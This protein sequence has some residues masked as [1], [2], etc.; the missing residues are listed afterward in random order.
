VLEH[1]VDVVLVP[2]FNPVL[3]EGDGIDRD[4]AVQSQTDMSP[5]G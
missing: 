3:A 2:R 4:Q 5:L 1:G